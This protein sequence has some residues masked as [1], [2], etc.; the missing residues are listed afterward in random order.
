M[1][2]QDLTQQM[3]RAVSDPSQWHDA[4]G[5]LCR[6]TGADRALIALRRRDSADIVIPETIA[7]QHNGP[8]IYG[9]TE[10]EVEAYLYQF[11]Q[12][13]P[14]TAIEKAN[15]PYFPYA[16]SKHISQGELRRTPFWNWLEP[17]GIDDS[18]VCEIGS[19]GDY[20]T[21]LNLYFGNT[22]PEKADRI[23]ARLNDTLKTLRAVWE[24]SREVQLA[25]ARETNL[26]RVF[27]KIGLPAMI[28]AA[29]G[30][31][32]QISAAMAEIGPRALGETPKVGDRLALPQD[33]EVVTS[34]Q[35]LPFRIRNTARR[36]GFPGRAML[37]P[38][39]HGE[40]SSG[41]P[42]TLSV[43]TLSEDKVEEH[44][45]GTQ[46]WEAS[47][48]TERE[49]TLVRMLAEGS[50]LKDAAV[51]MGISRQR[52]MQLWKSARD[53]LGVADVNELRFEHRLRAKAE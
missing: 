25:R 46:L 10:D 23:K 53:K 21:S 50:L 38:L 15:H 26:D 51:L 8:L 31:I 18:I 11:S 7:E 33:L 43:L 3:L 4:L 47:S 35:D 16:L 45:D 2:G 48:L 34:S 1:D 42:S 19:R 40:L 39:D 32:R 41:E 30:T 28:V 22:T 9:F 6:V 27:E 36:T 14:W 20:W 17:M 13:D 12:I 52:V 5:A 49:R 29:D 44:R 37:S 24:S